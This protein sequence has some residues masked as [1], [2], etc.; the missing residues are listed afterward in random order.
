[1][2]LTYKDVYVAQV[3]LGANPDQCVKA[4][5]EA[6]KFNGPSVIIAYSPCVNHGYNM[7]DSQLHCANSV[8]SGYNTLFRYNPT[9]DVP[10]Q[11]DSFDPTVNYREFVE[12][13]NRFKALDIVNKQNKNKL[14]K[15]SEQDAIKRRE[16]YTTLKNNKTET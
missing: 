13:E 4:F 8:K 5:I 10:M 1:M 9:L 7:K 6:E 14:L 16:G 11:V 3:S 15:L 2:L 12:S